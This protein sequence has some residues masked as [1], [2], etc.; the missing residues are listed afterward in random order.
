MVAPSLH[1]RASSAA[2][3]VYAFLARG[4]LRDCIEE[5]ILFSFDLL[6]SIAGLEQSKLARSSEMAG[7]SRMRADFGGGK[8]AGCARQLLTC[9]R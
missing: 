3:L 6:D 2:Y 1:Q 4:A 9:K 8:G 7:L 5:S